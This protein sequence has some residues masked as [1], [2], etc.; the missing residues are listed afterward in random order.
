MSTSFYAHKINYESDPKL[1]CSWK[2]SE[3]QREPKGSAKQILS[4]SMSIKAWCNKIR[5]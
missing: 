2:K 4:L 1:L 5:A 3:S